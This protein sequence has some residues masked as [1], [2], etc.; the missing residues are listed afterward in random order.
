MGKDGRQRHNT[1][2]V[3]REGNT[4]G[5]FYHTSERK[6]VALSLNL[7]L[8][9]NYVSTGL[10]LGLQD[11]MG[12]VYRIEG[13]SRTQREVEKQ[14]NGSLSPSALPAYATVSKSCRQEEPNINQLKFPHKKLCGDTDTWLVTHNERIGLA[15][16]MLNIK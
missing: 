2:A 8:S 3:D 6:T 13:G 12:L 1:N 16:P 7:H 15:C 4:V 14:P 11:P 5:R 9:V 10:F